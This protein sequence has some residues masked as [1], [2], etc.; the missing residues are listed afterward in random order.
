[1][2]RAGEVCYIR[3]DAS[4]TRARVLTVLIGWGALCA[5]GAA[6]YL[7]TRFIVRHLAAPRA[8]RW[9]AIPIAALLAAAPFADELY[10]EQQTRA[11]CRAS[12]GF[13]VNKTIFARSREEG[14]ARIQTVKVDSEEPHFWKHELLFLDRESGNELGRLRWFDRKHGWLQGNEPGAG[15][16]AFMK[17]AACPDPQ[18]FLANAAA[19]AQLVRTD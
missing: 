7:V 18:P 4:E 3:G 10:Y 11:A 9:F 16:S 12:G 13:A 8:R 6:V 1:V 17:A 5:F 19:R 2:G 14:L 15:Y